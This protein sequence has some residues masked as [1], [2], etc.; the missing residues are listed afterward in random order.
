[1]AMNVPVTVLPYIAPRKVRVQET[2]RICVKWGEPNLDGIPT[3][4]FRWFSRD[5]AAIAFLNDLVD[6][7]ISGRVVMK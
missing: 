5:N 7:G 6:R 4:Y 1:M 2:K 3:V